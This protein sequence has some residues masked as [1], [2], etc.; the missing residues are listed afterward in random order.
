MYI[1]NMTGLQCA[2]CNVPTVFHIILYG[3]SI[4][5]ILL[6]YAGWHIQSGRIVYPYGRSQGYYNQAIQSNFYKTSEIHVL[7]ED[8]VRQSI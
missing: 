5:C 2:Y 8:C 7:E 6:H 3:V 1:I 4:I